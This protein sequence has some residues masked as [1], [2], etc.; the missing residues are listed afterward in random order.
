MTNV[1][2]DPAGLLVEDCRR[3]HLSDSTILDC[4]HCGL[5]LKNVNDSYIH[6]LFIRDDRP[7]STSVSL[8]ETGGSGLTLRD[9]VMQIEQVR[10]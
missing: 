7:G 3:M 2:R 9:N 8:Q 6:D 10:D 4:D 5:W 1:W